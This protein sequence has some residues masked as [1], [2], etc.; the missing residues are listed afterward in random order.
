[1][2]LNADR[3]WFLSIDEATKTLGH[4]ILSISKM[5]LDDIRK[6]F[7][8]IQ[9]NPEDLTKIEYS[10]DHMRIITKIQD[11]VQNYIKLHSCATV[12][13]V[14]DKKDTEITLV[15]RIKAF[16]KYIDS[17]LEPEIKRIVPNNV[18]LNVPLEFIMGQN[19]KV[20][21]ICSS[22]IY[23]FS[24]HNVLIIKPVYK[25]QIHFKGCDE[26]YIAHWQGKCKTSYIANK[27]H[28]VALF[29]HIS[30]MFNFKINHLSKK[31]ISH[32]ADAVMGI[33]GIF[34]A[35][36]QNELV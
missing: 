22:A 35:D 1:M 4:C 10:R 29:E 30:K 3:W 28:C 20:N 5:N 8:K 14:P 2:N 13:L 33:F 23:A 24:N 12:D 26:T 17:N 32:V 18:K 31:E 6:Q 27:K 21:A 7:E 19:H 25:N 36:R 9:Q 15:E 34:W 16:R 11:L